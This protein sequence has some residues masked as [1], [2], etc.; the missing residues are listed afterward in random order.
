MIKRSI[1]QYPLFILPDRFQK[2][3]QVKI[4]KNWLTIKSELK[5]SKTREKRLSRVGC[6]ADCRVCSHADLRL[7]SGYMPL[8]A[9]KAI[10]LISGGVEISFFN[11]PLKRIVFVV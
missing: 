5:N 10:N 6:K 3:C 2:I 4:P 8:T 1:S 7:R 11:A 9:E